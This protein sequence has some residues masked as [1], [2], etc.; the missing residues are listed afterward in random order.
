MLK[1]VKVLLPLMLL[2]LVI[3]GCSG[4]KNPMDNMDTQA[5]RSANMAIPAGAT[6][7][8]ATFHIY[9][10][11]ASGQHVNAHRITDAWDEGT[12]TWNSF[13]GAYDGTAEGGFMADAV[14]WKTV[15]VTTLVQAW[16]TGAQ[17][18][19][20]ILLDQDDLEYPRTLYGSREIDNAPWLE[21]CYSYNGSE[22]CDTIVAAADAYIFEIYPD[23]NFGYGE[24][25]YTGRYADGEPKKQAL[26]YFP[27]ETQPPE[28]AAI[29]DYVW[30]DMNED[31]I[32]DMDEVGVEGVPVQL[33]DCEGNVLATTATD[34]NGYYLFDGLQPGMYNVHFDIPD[35]W[36]LSPQD[37]GSDDA[38]D[39][40][41]D[42]NGFTVCTELVAGETDLTW[43]AGIYRPMQVG[44]TRTIGYWKTH[45]GF[46]PQP[47]MVSQYLPIWLGDAGGAKSMQ[48][49]SAAMAV[50]V[51][52]QHY[53]GSPSNGITKMM[54]QLLGAKLNFA[55]GAS[56]ADV[57][58]A[59]TAAD[60]FLADHDYTE[61][62][63]LSRADKNMVRDWHEMF[64]DYNNGCIG[65]GHCD[66]DPYG[67]P[68][69]ED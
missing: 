34:A 43:D 42:M 12:V 21:V 30:Y 29:G 6:I 13:G 62:N 27:M 45:A 17:P 48:V 3:A 25:L 63:S 59:V 2:A 16:Y 60:A 55:A 35:G 37:Q 64:D 8:S 65:P 14:D 15:D 20:G 50:N 46:G 57:S 32:Q 19:Y 41:A 36:M 26:V 9:L 69:D 22:A 52:S 44:C 31:G 10:I 58:A 23:S 47:D 5:L 54:A 33:M 40:D 4:D 24:L 49:T 51:L 39:S 53:Y 11:Y 56:D 38:I 61:W 66:D 28:L 7:E 1:T 67:V 18:N 68:C